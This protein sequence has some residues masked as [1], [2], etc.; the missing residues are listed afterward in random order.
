MKTKF[1]LSSLQHSKMA[2]TFNDSFRVKAGRGFVNWLKMSIYIIRGSISAS[3][4]RSSVVY[5]RYL[6]RLYKS[7]GVKFVVIYTKACHILLLQSMGGMKVAPQ[8]LGVAVSRNR[9]GIPRIIPRLHRQ[10][11]KQGDTKLLRIWLSW[12]SIY[13]V[14]EFKPKLSFSTIT[15]QGLASAPQFIT[16][17]SEQIPAFVKSY[18]KLGPSSLIEKLGPIVPLRITKAS[19][20]A[21]GLRR[22]AVVAGLLYKGGSIRSASPL[23]IILSCA[24]VTRSSI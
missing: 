10:A 9:H 3:V 17:V 13:R 6:H 4:A 15:D 14:L 22:G 16:E 2:R 7:G 11:L 23:G 19:P 21:V 12:F 1:S 8:H 18:F 5:L 20:V 24:Y